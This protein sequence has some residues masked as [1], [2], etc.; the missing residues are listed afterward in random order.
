MKV[1]LRASDEGL[2]ESWRK[3]ITLLCYTIHIL[4]EGCE[5]TDFRQTSFGSTYMALLGCARTMK[6]ATPWTET[7]ENQGVIMKKSREGLYI[8]QADY[9]FY[10]EQWETMRSRSE[11]IEGAENASMTYSNDELLGII[12]DCRSLNKTSCGIAVI[13][14]QQSLVADLVLDIGILRHDELLM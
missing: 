2:E 4:R 9:S 8:T 13:G 6:V 11:I 5:F 1:F 3:A 7:N 10:L 14:D 12:T